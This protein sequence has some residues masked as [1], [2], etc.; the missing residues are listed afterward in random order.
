MDHQLSQLERQL[1]QLSDFL[2]GTS[3]N[4]FPAQPRDAA[5]VPPVVPNGWAIP[6][7]VDA[8]ASGSLRTDTAT[9]AM[10]GG[11]TDKTAATSDKTNP[12]LPLQALVEDDLASGTYDR[13]LCCLDRVLT[14]A[15][16]DHQMHRARREDCG[17]TSK[18]IPFASL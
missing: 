14:D 1:V 15:N 2:G 10:Q 17:S 11:A 12:L 5:P 4:M 8:T 16:A 13:L 7:A 9:G 3:A 18:R 6:T